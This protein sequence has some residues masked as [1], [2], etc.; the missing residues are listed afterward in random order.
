MKLW[1][2]SDV[3]LEISNSKINFARP[4][5]DIIVIAGD[6]TYADRV[7]EVVKD[8]IY[9][10]HLPIIYVA[11][12]HEFY[13]SHQRSS[14]FETDQLLLK[15]AERDSESWSHRFHVLDED[16][17]VI[18]GIRFVGATLWTDFKLNL[19]NESQ[20]SARMRNS[21]NL[22]R[23]F[24]SIRMRSGERFSA[25]D[26][27]A[28]N[29]SNAAYLRH[30]MSENFNGKKVIVSHH[31]PHPACISERYQDS[32]ANYLFSNSAEAFDDLLSSDKAPALWI[33]GHS[34]EAS[35]VLIGRTRVVCNPFGYDFEKGKN[36]FRSDLVI[37][38]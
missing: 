37:E 15:L 29:A 14:P 28:L 2:W 17:V 12:N 11:G 30:Q 19:S 36:G 5:A 9:R 8:I 31:L 24:T 33:C 35:D 34:H 4:D 32:E 25:A 3:H 22:L 18:D 7:S 26:M 6:L 38:I 23:D 27:I 13:A 21:E 1:I 20:L 16:T 10:Y